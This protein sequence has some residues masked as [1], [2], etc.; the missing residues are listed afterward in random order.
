MNFAVRPEDE[1]SSDAN[2]CLDIADN[3]G[4]VGICMDDE[5]G[6]DG[7]CRD[8]DKG[9]RRAA[10]GRTYATMTFVLKKI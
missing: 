5:N 10:K 8:E 9:V 7:P 4:G 6:P 3:A 2:G 1:T